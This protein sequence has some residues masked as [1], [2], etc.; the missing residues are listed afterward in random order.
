MPTQLAQCWFPGLT[1]SIVKYKYRIKYTEA[2]L[3]NSTRNSYGLKLPR[4]RLRFKILICVIY[5]SYRHIF[6]PCDKAFV[7]QE[8]P[9]SV[10]EWLACWTQPKVEKDLADHA[11][12]FRRGG[13]H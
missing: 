5:Y 13:S 11:T 3:S 7:L 6:V 12:I 10:A 1:I 8:E 2:I 4:C 9:G